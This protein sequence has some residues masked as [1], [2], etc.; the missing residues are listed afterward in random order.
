MAYID[1]D[2]ETNSIKVIRG[3][4]S[5]NTDLEEIAAKGTSYSIYK[6]KES[7]EFKGLK[8]N[9][10]MS[11][12]EL[13]GFKTEMIFKE[14]LEKNNVPYLYVGQGPLGIERSN[15]LKD[16]LNS[17][18]PD[19]MVNLPDIGSLFF[20]IK[21]RRKKGFPNSKAKYFQLFESEV[22]SLINLHEQLLVPVWVAFMDESEL[23]DSSNPISK[24][25]IVSI[26]NMKKFYDKLKGSLTDRENEMLTS[27]RIPDELLFTLN[28]HFNFKVGG[29]TI[30]QAVIIDFSKKYKGLIRKI[31]DLIKNSIRTEKILKSNITNSLIKHTGDF[32]FRNEVERILATLIKEEVIVFE[33]KKPLSLLGE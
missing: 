19:F 25:N 11:E 8:L 28:D 31:E 23:N 9:N 10:Y 4:M 30:D 27:I 21:C 17:K 12:L 6:D 18:R 16:K 3:I 5:L 22:I 32:A 24:F 26:S 2:S 14:L 33:P 29:T 7:K 13:K 1:F 20:D 15:V